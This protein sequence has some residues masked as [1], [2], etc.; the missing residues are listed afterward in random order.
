MKRIKKGRAPDID[1]VCTEIIAVEEVR[2]SWMK[3]LLNMLLRP[4]VPSVL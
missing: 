1:E 3:R 2:V 4:R